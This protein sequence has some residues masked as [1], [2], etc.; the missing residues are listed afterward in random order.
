V[1][2]IGLEERIAA[3]AM[4]LLERLRPVAVLVEGI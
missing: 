2:S 4:Q 1:L 3:H